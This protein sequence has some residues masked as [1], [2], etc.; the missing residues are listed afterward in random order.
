MKK[1]IIAII[2]FVFL[3]G[4]VQA[5]AVNP[6]YGIDLTCTTSNYG[7]FL[8]SNGIRIVKN[9]C[10]NNDDVYK[11]I[12]QLEQTINDLETRIES[13][14]APAGASGIDRTAALEIRIQALETS[15]KS[16]QDNI[17][18]ALKNIIILLIKR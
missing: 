8:D 5:F 18:G 2:L 16:L 15:M 7:P 3:L 11:R 17:M 1:I 9:P 14:Q 6:G 13:C 10:N 4:P 12:A